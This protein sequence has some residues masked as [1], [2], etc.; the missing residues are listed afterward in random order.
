MAASPAAMAPAMSSARRNGCQSAKLERLRTEQH[1]AAALDVAGGEEIRLAVDGGRALRR[2]P[3]AHVGEVLA[4]EV[5]RRLV[6]VDDLDL[7]VLLLEEGLQPL[8]PRREAARRTRSSRCEMRSAWWARSSRLARSTARR[9]SA[10]PMANVTPIETTT[11]TT[12]AKNRRLRSGGNRRAHGETALYPAPRTV[13]I[14]V[15][16]PSLRRSWPTWTSTVRVPPG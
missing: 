1:E 11:M 6:K 10:T 2:S 8:E 4:L 14:R 9:D 5:R 13:L 15:G 16:R 12:I 3:S 7:L